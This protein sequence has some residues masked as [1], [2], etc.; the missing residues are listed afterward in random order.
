MRKL[1]IYIPT[2]KG[3]EKY[4]G[5]LVPASWDELNPRQLLRCMRWLYGFSVPE[6]AS[7]KEA[8]AVKAMQKRM[9]LKELL[10]LK[11]WYFKALPDIAIAQLHSCTDFLF[12]SN[13]LTKQLLPAIGSRFR[14]WYGPKERFRNLSFLEFIFADT[15]HLRFIKTGDP[16]CL[17]KLLAVLYRPKVGFHFIR[18]RLSSYSGDIREPF[19][20]HLLEARAAQMQRLPEDVKLA[21]LAWYRGCRNRL[22]QTYDLVFTSENEEQ[23]TKSSGWEPVFRQMAGG[24]FGDIERVGKVPVHTILAEMQDLLHQK[25][26]WERKNPVKKH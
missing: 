10:G 14:K 9:L 13:N 25:Q 3:K 4:I 16:D 26:E 2:S 11:P 19:N 17:H 8:Q 1:E 20:E 18:K 6:G 24:K 15:Y 12:S 21:V 23:A 7:E 5:T 22:E